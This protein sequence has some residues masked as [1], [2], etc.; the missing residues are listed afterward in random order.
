M[1]RSAERE[2]VRDVIDVNESAV[3]KNGI[4]H[5]NPNN[6]CHC[7][8]VYTFHLDDS[9]TQQDAEKGTAQSDIPDANRGEYTITNGT[10][11]L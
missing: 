3:F 11:I 2:H 8:D 1:Q 10:L 5:V 6:Y 7:Y 4:Y 9:N